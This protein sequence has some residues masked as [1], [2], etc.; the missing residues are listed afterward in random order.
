MNSCQGTQI[1]LCPMLVSCRL[2][3]LSHK[4]T[5][6]GSV[7]VGVHEVNILVFLCSS[8][9]RKR[10]K[11]GLYLLWDNGSYLHDCYEP[12]CLDQRQYGVF[13]Q[14]SHLPVKNILRT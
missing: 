1:I 8:S 10:M 12:Y 11:N 7:Q 5:C 3:H 6:S 13:L 4:G 9:K 14:S 2:I